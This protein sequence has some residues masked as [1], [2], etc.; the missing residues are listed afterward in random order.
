MPPAAAMAGSAAARHSF[1]SPLTS[2]RLISSP[3]TK[4][5]RAINPSLIQSCRLLA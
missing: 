4:K 2:S 5:K 1:N 3:T